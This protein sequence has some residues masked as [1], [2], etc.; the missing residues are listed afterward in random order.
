M[1]K[2]KRVLTAPI[3]FCSWFQETVNYK[4]AKKQVDRYGISANTVNT[5]LL[6]GAAWG[7]LFAPPPYSIASAGIL[8]SDLSIAGAGRIANTYF[9]WNERGKTGSY[10]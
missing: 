5:V 6:M 4:Q 8:V 9:G 1:G 10:A 3:D 7:L 2:V